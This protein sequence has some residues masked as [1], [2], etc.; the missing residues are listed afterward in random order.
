MN[1]YENYNQS[2]SPGKGWYTE[3]QEKTVLRQ[4]PGR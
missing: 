4:N 1:H 3:I 2:Q